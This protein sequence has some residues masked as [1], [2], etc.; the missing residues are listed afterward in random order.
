MAKHKRTSE[1]VNIHR[2]HV[3]Y[4]KPTL[5]TTCLS[6]NVSEAEAANITIG[7][8]A[9]AA[10]DVAI[11]TRN[12]IPMY[13]GNLNPTWQFWDRVAEAIQKNKGVSNA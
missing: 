2:Y 7:I 8:F 13:T 9:A 12:Q 1:A 11:F 4:Y 5:T 10:Y 3:D 6:A